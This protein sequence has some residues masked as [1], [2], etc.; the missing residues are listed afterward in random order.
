MDSIQYYTYV[1][2]IFKA[3]MLLNRCTGWPGGLRGGS[4]TGGPARQDT[5]QAAIIV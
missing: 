4:Q 2:R 5:R 1:L 3:N